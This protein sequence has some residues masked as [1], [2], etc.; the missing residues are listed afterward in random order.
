MWCHRNPA[1]T[2]KRQECLFKGHFQ[3]SSNHHAHLYLHV[4]F[5]KLEVEPACHIEQ[6]HSG[7]PAQETEHGAWRQIWIPAWIDS[8]AKKARC[9]NG[10]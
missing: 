3:R 5:A 10:S 7:K 4:L 6:S 8:L 2:N 9:R 1:L